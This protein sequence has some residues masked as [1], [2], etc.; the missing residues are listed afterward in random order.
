MLQEIR[1]LLTH[2]FPPGNSKRGNYV[3]PKNRIVKNLRALLKNVIEDQT[4]ETT[5]NIILCAALNW[6]AGDELAP[7]VQ[8]SPYN[9]ILGTGEFYAY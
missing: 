2:Y 8:K 4:S 6:D 5:L 9:C 1:S 3:G 7:Q